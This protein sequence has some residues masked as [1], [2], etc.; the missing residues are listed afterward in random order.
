MYSLQSLPSLFWALFAASFSITMTTIPDSK[1]EPKAKA[2]AKAETIDLHR[3]IRC[4][5]EVEG[6]QWNWPG[7]KLCISRDTWY[8]AGSKKSYIHACD[9]TVA[10]EVAARL[11]TIADGHLRKH[12]IEPTV[13]L[14]ALRWKHGLEGMIRH[15]DDKSDYADRVANLYYDPSFKEEV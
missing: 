9:P 12:D 13:K 10:R 1:P 11:L 15:K 6:G 8:D 5:E 2:V 4:L 3:L 7:G 14:L